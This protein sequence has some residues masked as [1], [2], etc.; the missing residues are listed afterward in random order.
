MK[1][2]SGDYRIM[3]LSDIFLSQIHVF[4]TPLRRFLLGGTRQT[5]AYLFTKTNQMRAGDMIFH[6]APLQNS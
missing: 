5:S 6:R 1:M 3:R 4:S 2:S